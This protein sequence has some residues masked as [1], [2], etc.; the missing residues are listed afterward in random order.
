M[1]RI[2]I[3]NRT[4]ENT[5]TLICIWNAESI[6]TFSQQTKK[7]T[8]EKKCILYD[9]DVFNV[10]LHHICETERTQDKSIKTDDFE[11]IFVVPD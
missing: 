7:M 3:Q 6:N 4:A 1:R 2:E 8:I 9:G 11:L 10:S 5:T